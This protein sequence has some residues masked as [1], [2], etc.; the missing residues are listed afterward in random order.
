MHFVNCVLE[1]LLTGLVLS[2]MLGTVFF[3]LIRNSI[4]FGHR[5]GAFI[6]LGVILC[7]VIFISLAIASSNFAQFLSTYQ[8]EVSIIGGTVLIV[9]G[10]VMFFKATPKDTE[11]KLF[12]KQHKMTLYLVGTGFILN[13]V[14]PVNFFSWLS[15]SSVLR[16]KMHYNNQDLILYFTACLFSIFIVELGIAYFA[17]K[18]KN[19]MQ[20]K[21]VK[22]INQIAAAVFV[23]VGIKLMM[24]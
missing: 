14:N 9:M 23:I 24:S 21:T 1:G 18:L 4:A 3:S 19:I 2:L 7:D 16:I 6:A 20:A 13:A 17:S 5:S 10:A 22:F 8:S 11:G 12:E 15:I